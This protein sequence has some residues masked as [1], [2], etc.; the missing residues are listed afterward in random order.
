MRQYIEP[1]TGYIVPEAEWLFRGSPAW[2]QVNGVSSAD[3]GIIDVLTGVA[4]ILIPGLGSKPAPPPSTSLVPQLPAVIKAAPTVAVV[5]A[6]LGPLLRTIWKYI[7]AGYT[8]DTVTDWLVS[9]YT[10]SRENAQGLI[11]QA[12]RTKG[13]RRRMNPCNPRALKRAIARINRFDK[14][15]DATQKIM[16]KYARRK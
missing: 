10:M 1:G 6:R 2:T 11:A 12:I 9:S 15:A 14:F 3:P 13:G 5:G 4:K 16:R 8:F 7:V